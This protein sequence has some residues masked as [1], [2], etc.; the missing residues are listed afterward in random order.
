[1][2]LTQPILQVLDVSLGRL[3]DALNVSGPPLQI[4]RFPMI[5]LGQSKPPDD[6]PDNRI[7]V[8]LCKSEVFQAKVSQVSQSS[9]GV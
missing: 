6:I 3:S 2:A 1:M 9:S 4:M 7:S 8:Q 5:C